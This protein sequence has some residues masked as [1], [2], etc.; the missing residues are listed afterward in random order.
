MLWNLGSNDY[1]QFA[2][3]KQPRITR[4]IS[5]VLEGKKREVPVKIFNWGCSYSARKGLQESAHAGICN[6]SVVQRGTIWRLAGPLM[7]SEYGYNACVINKPFA[8]DE[9]GH[10]VNV[11]GIQIP[12]ENNNNSEH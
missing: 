9:L 7:S 12:E 10:L 11:L 4:G 2:V 1:L 6:L 3:T 5:Q 8:Y